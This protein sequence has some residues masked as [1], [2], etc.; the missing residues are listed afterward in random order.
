MKVLGPASLF[1]RSVIRAT[2]I[3]HVLPPFAPNFQLPTQTFL[4]ALD[5]YQPVV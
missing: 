2:G 3:R 5:V 1:S 4:L